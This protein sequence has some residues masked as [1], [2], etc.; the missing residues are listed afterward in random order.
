[1]AATTTPAGRQDQAAR[2]RQRGRGLTQARP[3]QATHSRSVPHNGPHAYRYGI[4]AARH[5]RRSAI[6]WAVRSWIPVTA[7]S[8]VTRSA[9]LT[10]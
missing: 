8:E 2:R 1:M 4:S 3:V 5:P 10:A 7:V 9:G 6:W